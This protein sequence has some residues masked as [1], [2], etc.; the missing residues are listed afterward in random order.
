MSNSGKEYR[1]RGRG[2]IAIE[3]A[4]LIPETHKA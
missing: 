4:P 1:D 3:S 2:V